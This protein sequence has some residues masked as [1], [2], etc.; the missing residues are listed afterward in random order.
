MSRSRLLWLLFAATLLALA[1]GPLRELSF[2]LGKW[3]A[4]AGAWGVLV[5]VGLYAFGA[6]LVVPGSALTMLAG[7]AYGIGLGFALAWPA[8]SLAAWI[9]FV[10]ARSLGK[11]WVED[12]LV[13]FPRYRALSAAAEVE[14][15][16]WVI[17]LRLSPIVPFSLLNYV[18]GVSKM[19]ARQFVV[20]SAIG[21]APSTLT[22]VY[23]GSALSVLADPAQPAQSP[24]TRLL[25]WVGLCATLVAA[26]MIT[27]AV[28]RRTAVL[29]EPQRFPPAE[30]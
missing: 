28:R 21:K 17:L 10:V 30:G 2:G 9:N 27:R 16:T 18:M 11:H 26:W 12:R 22:Y 1:I 25:F 7:F 13:A 3:F 19:P 14:G 8:A 29:L 6:L 24:W 4:G 5:Y 20:A 15:F 23:L